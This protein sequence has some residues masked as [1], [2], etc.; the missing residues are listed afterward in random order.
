MR[1]D[2]QHIGVPFRMRPGL[3]RMADGEPHL[4]ALDPD[5]ALFRE[6]SLVSRAGR[7]VHC[8]PGFDAR[9]ALA[10]IHARMRRDGIDVPAD[11]R[12]PLEL[13]LAQD[14]AV[15]DLAS[16]GVPWMCVCV[17]SGWAPEDKLG[18]DLTAI[19]APVA[20]GGA[21]A[22]AWPQLARLLTAGGEW[23]RHVWT[24]TP[25][26]RY[27][28]HPHRHAPAPWPEHGDP[29]DFARACL[30]RSERQTFFPVRD[31]HGRNLAQAVFTIAVALEPLTGA[32]RDAAHAR[33][34]LQ[35]IAS[36]TPAV[37]AYKRLDGARTR[38][39]AWLSARAEENPATPLQPV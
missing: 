28:Q 34:L 25:S 21:L 20:D 24:I 37:L 33:V 38:L 31:R 12:A 1:F 7:A 29:A 26:P 6:K 5:S 36:M 14:L 23:E 35:A 4:V 13:A 39:L 32:V 30:L 10:A 18:R 11:P 22:A 27:D 16:G 3:R 19:H 9:G 15:L 8:S 17:P 2:F